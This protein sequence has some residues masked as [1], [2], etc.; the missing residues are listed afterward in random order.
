MLQYSVRWGRLEL[1]L[2]AAAA[3]LASDVRGEISKWLKRVTTER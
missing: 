1:G 3:A 2:D